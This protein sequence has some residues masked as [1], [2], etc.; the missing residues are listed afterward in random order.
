MNLH[1]LAGEV[2]L[3]LGALVLVVSALGLWLLPDTL[4]RQHAGTKAVTLGLTLLALGVAARQTDASWSLRMALLVVFLFSTLP[5]AAQVL[6]RASV[7]E[8]GQEDE[9][10]NS[11][12]VEE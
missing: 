9:V 5:I 2:L 4:S 8:S 7:R 10:A 3:A 12:R 6:A 1:L 11:P